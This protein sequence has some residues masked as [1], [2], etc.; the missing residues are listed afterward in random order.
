MERKLQFPV[1][2]VVAWGKDFLVAGGGGGTARSG[3]PNGLAVLRWPGLTLVATKLGIDDSVTNLAVAPDG[4][5]LAFGHGCC[6]SLARLLRNDDDDSGGSVQLDVCTTQTT[7]ERRSVEARKAAGD[8]E[9]DDE[10]QRAVTFS[11]DD[12]RTLLTGASTGQLRLWRVSETLTEMAPV[13]ELAGSKGAI[14]GLALNAK[15]AA[16]TAMGDGKC[17]VWCLEGATGVLQPV[18]VISARDLALPKLRPALTCTLR[19]CAFIDGADGELV[20]AATQTRG[21]TWLVDSRGPASVVA[22]SGRLSCFASLRATVALGN[23]EGD[24]L[25]MD[26]SRGLS[27]RTTTLLHSRGRHSFVVTAVAFS[28]GGTHVISSGLDSRVCATQMRPPPSPTRLPLRGMLFVAL[29]VA[30]LAVIY[31]V[32]FTHKLQ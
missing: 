18:R 16:A 26:T 23:N 11:V 31:A 4:S 15:H 29:L 6:C 20:M 27:S 1:F 7:V 8:E 25:A 21:C 24:V 10:L 12:A 22:T 13:A 19:G 30:L 9:D 2:C 5:G 3:V 28:P 14:T 17:R 32:F